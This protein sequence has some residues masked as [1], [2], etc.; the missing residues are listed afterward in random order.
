MEKPQG[1]CSFM[2]RRLHFAVLLFFVLMVGVYVATAL[3]YAVHISIVQRRSLFS[4][5]GVGHNIKRLA[6]R[7]VPQSGL[8]GGVFPAVLS[9][10]EGGAE[11][12]HV[13]L[14][15]CSTGPPY[16]QMYRVLQP[17]VPLMKQRVRNP[18]LPAD[19]PL[20]DE[21]TEHAP[22]E[23]NDRLR[24]A[25]PSR[26]RYVLDGL[27]PGRRYMIRLSFLGSP[28][29]GFDL[30]LYQVRRSRALAFLE[31]GMR[32][33]GG[34][35][36]QARGWA[37]EP[38][39]T[40][41]LMFSTSQHSAHELS[42]EDVWVD[43]EDVDD[44]SSVSG[45]DASMAHRTFRAAS[46]SDNPFLPVIEVRPRALSIPVDAH[47]LPLVRFNLEVEQLSLSF[48]PQMTLS[49]ITYAAGVLILVG[50]LVVYTLTSSAIAGGEMIPP[51]SEL[52]DGE[53]RSAQ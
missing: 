12:L 7:L 50:Y 8:L 22:G 2:M 1:I 31:D 49:L 9:D 37:E 27:E 45:L 17:G 28:S 46:N 4:E 24:H 47:R 26:Q 40:E 35:S 48:L 51:Y 19:V 39:D 11:P 15:C 16:T 21:G 34:S 6:Q 23:R 44:A 29:V 36:E 18:S 14:K 41:L 30:V 13:T 33:P 42:A 32:V 3:Y 43:R 38:Q 5:A 10:T 53:C 20:W 52:V 25:V